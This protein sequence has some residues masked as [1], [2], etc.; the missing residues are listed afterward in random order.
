MGSP[1]CRVCSNS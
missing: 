1:E